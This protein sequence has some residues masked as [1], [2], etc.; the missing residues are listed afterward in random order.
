MARQLFHKRLS[1]SP[2]VS[3]GAAR[4]QEACDS[5]VLLTGLDEVAGPRRGPPQKLG[6]FLLLPGVVSQQ[7]FQ[8]CALLQLRGVKATVLLSFLFV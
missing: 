4:R 3:R 8:R 5:S 2:R 7:P 1:F 6:V